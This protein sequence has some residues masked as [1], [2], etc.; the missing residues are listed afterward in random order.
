MQ[1]VE[2]V[3]DVRK[4]RHVES[5]FVWGLVPTMGALH[6]GHMSLVNMARSDCD[7]VLVSIFIN[8]IQFDDPTDLEAYP[9]TLDHDLNLLREAGV[10]L[11]W[12]PTPEIMYP[13]GFQSSVHVN[14]LT[15]SLEGAHR[16]GHFDGVTT[17]VA[18]LFNVTQPHYAYFGQKD[19]QQVAV[20]K[21]M[22]RDLNF[23]LE[24]VVGETIREADGLALSSRN[25]NLAPA[26]RQ[27]ATVLSRA[28]FAART[29]WTHGARD[30]EH[31]RQHMRG[32]ISAEPLARIDYVSVADPLTLEEQQGEVR[33]ALLSMA[34]T[35]GETRLIDNVML[36]EQ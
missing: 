22:V 28:L 21:Q 32:I 17:V 20:I 3:Q 1:I 9:R 25:K 4:I 30:A 19:A 18:K 14:V 23:N 5:K 11:V 15:R 12:T 35:I 36:L 31:L 33:N 29:A 16:P 7:R 26:E 27:A 24:V 8:P 10:D 6:A 34:V 2:S 13:A